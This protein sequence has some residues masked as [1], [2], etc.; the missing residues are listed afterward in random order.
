MKIF[1]QTTPGDFILS[2]DAQHRE[3]KDATPENQRFE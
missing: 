2:R 1:E 3:S